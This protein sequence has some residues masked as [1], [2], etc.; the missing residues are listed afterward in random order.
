MSNIEVRKRTWT[1]LEFSVP[2]PCVQADIW[3]AHRAAT[4]AWVEA[5]GYDP[6]AMP[7]DDAFKCEARDDSIVFIV[8]HEEVS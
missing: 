3:H 5:T 1:T 2:S 7:P 8:T 6:A 4:R